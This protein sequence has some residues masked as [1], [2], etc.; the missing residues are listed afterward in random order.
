VQIDQDPGTLVL[1]RG[2]RS[3]HRVTPVKGPRARINI[4]CSYSSEPGHAFSESH[5]EAYA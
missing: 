2:H 4:V 5:R 3:L 1:F